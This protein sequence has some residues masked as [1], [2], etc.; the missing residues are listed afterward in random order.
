LGSRVLSMH[1][2]SVYVVMH[3]LPPTSTSDAIKLKGR[4]AGFRITFAIL[5]IAQTLQHLQLVTSKEAGFLIRPLPRLLWLF[6]ASD[7][8]CQCRAARGFPL[9]AC[10]V[11]LLQ[12]RE[13]PASAGSPPMSRPSSP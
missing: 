4:A 13:C 8:R 6:G 11:P 5:R 9:T 2:V 10:R 12:Q 7:I 1:I 3:L